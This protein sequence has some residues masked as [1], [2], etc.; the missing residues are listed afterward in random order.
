M[1]MLG[2]PVSRITRAMI[3]APAEN[4]SNQVKNFSDEFGQV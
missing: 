4:T 3:S 2:A 1:A